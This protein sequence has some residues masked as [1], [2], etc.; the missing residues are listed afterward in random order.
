MCFD[1]LY[2]VCPRY[3][4]F[5][6]YFSELSYMYIGFHVF[7]L[8]F[9]ENFIFIYG[10]S[11][12]SLIIFHENPCS[13]SRDVPCGRAEMTKLAVAVRNFV[14]APKTEIHSHTNSLVPTQHS[15][16]ER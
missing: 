14:N 2:N 3:F 6:E 5:E 9:C 11:K 16:L 10:F 8:D 1:F 4:P 7:L 12:N 15:V 13:G